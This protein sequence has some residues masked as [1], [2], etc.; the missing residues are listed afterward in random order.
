[1]SG[2]VRRYVWTTLILVLSTGILLAQ[3]KTDSQEVL[4]RQSDA[5]DIIKSI[6]RKKGHSDTIIEKHPYLSVLP[7]AGYNPSVG[8]SVGVTSTDAKLYGDPKTTTLSVFNANAYISTYGLFSFEM[9]ENVFTSNNK[10]NIT[11]GIQA[12]KTVAL[13]YGVGTGRPAQG[14]GTFA[15]NNFPLANN[16]DVFEIDFSYLK[17]NERIYRQI[18]KNIFVGAGLIFDFYTNID[19]VRKVGPNISTHNYRYSQINAYPTDGY[20]ANGFLLNFEYDSRDQINRAY[21]GLYADFVARFNQTWMGS[22]HQAIQLKT[23]VRKYWS[24]SKKNPEHVIA[25][26]L[27]GCYLLDGTIPYLELPGTGSDA[28]NRLGR[29]YTIG[30]FKGPSFFYSEGEYRFPLTANKLLSGVAFANFQT[31]DNQARNAAK[32]IRLFE[33]MEPGGGI[34]LRLLF[35]KYSRS[36][37]CIDYGRGNYTS[38]GLFLGLNEVF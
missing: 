22:N 33:Y 10:F 14:D 24:L 30:R 5:K 17:I 9:K 35:N 34:G 15:I 1:V 4:N 23:E 8:L 28:S 12:G 29:G 11:G 16:A 27:W 36:N 37:L 32:N 6:F 38:R 25:F 21:K 18:F 20:Q 3:E 7:S 2:K 26:W 31:A 19:D 13:D